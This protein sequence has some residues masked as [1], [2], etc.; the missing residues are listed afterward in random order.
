MTEDEVVKRLEEWG[1]DETA[2]MLNQGKLPP[3]WERTAI[4][5]LAQNKAL[6]SKKAKEQVR[7][8]NILSGCALVVSI[9]AL[10]VSLVPYLS[11]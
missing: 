4:T 11:R 9:A 3:G 8:A 10:A 6:E 1:P 5:W 2:L 7:N